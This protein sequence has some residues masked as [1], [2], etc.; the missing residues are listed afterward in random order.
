MIV[1]IKKEKE[2]QFSSSRKLNSYLGK[3]LRI[4]N[5]PCKI[6]AT[7]ARYKHC[8]LRIISHWMC[9]YS[10]HSNEELI[11]MISENGITPVT[12]RQ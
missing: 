4:S 6:S 11:Q 2:K 8:I 3:V 9:P 7:E 10:S 5:Y 12:N 1:I